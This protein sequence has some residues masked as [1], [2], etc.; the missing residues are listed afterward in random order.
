MLGIRSSLPLVGMVAALVPLAAQSYTFEKIQSPKPVPNGTYGQGIN[1]RGEI[2]GSIN[3]RDK[4]RNAWRGFRRYSDGQFEVPII[5]PLAQN[6]ATYVQGINDSHVIVGFYIGADGNYHGFLDNGGSFTT[7]DPQEGASTQIYGINDFGQFVGAFGNFS[8]LITH[9]F[10]NTNGAVTQIDVPDS[11]ST[12]VWAIDH[13]G[14]LAGCSVVEANERAFLRDASGKY[15]L[16]RPAHSSTSFCATGVSSD[17][18]MVVGTYFEKTGSRVHGFVYSYGAAGASPDAA[19]GDVPVTI[20]DY[21]GAFFTYV[22]GIN[23][24]GQLSGYASTVAG[25]PFGFIATP[26]TV[27]AN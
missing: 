12:Q 9:G 14:A 26:T 8:S 18:G 5:D 23:S 25:P 10:V 4:Q 24:K 27:P 15:I 13:A 17:L 1:S 7:F 19:T 22:Y 20:I 3:F 2:V 21:P 6:G 11:T 16:F